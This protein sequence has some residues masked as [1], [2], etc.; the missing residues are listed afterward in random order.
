[1]DILVVKTFVRWC[2][3]IL[4]PPLH[5]MAEWAG[6]VDSDDAGSAVELSNLHRSS[7]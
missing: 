2:L 5:S 6:V 7:D 1:M 3:A 4:G